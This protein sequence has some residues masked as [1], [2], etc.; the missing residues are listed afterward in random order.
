MWINN[1]LHCPCFPKAAKGNAPFSLQYLNHWFPKWVLTNARLGVDLFCSRANFGHMNMLCSAPANA[2]WSHVLTE[3]PH[4]YEK[5]NIH[6]KPSS[7]KRETVRARA[8][9]EAWWDHY[10]RPQWASQLMVGPSRSTCHLE[11]SLPLLPLPSVVFAW[12]QH[13]RSPVRTRF[14]SCFC[15]VRSPTIAD[16][17]MF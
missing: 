5:Y 1:I 4:V 14:L 16:P 7:L 17:P 8:P 15:D 2:E 6:Q 3:I 11:L 9:V 13:H 12:F 10:T